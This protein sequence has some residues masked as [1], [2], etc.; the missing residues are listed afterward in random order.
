MICGLG[1]SKKR[2]RIM[3]RQSGTSDGQTVFLDKFMP[4]LEVLQ[5]AVNYAVDTSNERWVFAV[6]ISELREM[7]LSDND[8]RWLVCK[9]VVQQGKDLSCAGG[10][11]VESQATPSLRFNEQSCF[12]L[13]D[14]GL[15]FVS[16]MEHENLPGALPDERPVAPVSTRPRWLAETR[17]LYLDQRVIKRFRWQAAN[18]ETV[19]AAF[20]EEGWPPVVLDPLP[21]KTE[22]DCKRRLH[23]TIKALN[24]NQEHDLIRFHGNGSG[25]GVRWKLVCDPL[26]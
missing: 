23:D 1:D 10:R 22:I 11:C 18:Q 19:L 21:P 2:G 8:V 4:A 15:D 6:A 5:E 14:A 3:L 25:E 9:G 24:R 7:G 16:R 12:V 17:E 26:P 20:E 13:T